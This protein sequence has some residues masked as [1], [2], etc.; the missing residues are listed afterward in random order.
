MILVLLFQ[1][2]LQCLKNACFR[3]FLKSEC[4]STWYCRW[5]FIAHLPNLK[6]ICKSPCK[7]LKSHLDLKF[8][9]ARNWVLLWELFVHSLWSRGQGCN[10]QKVETVDLQTI[11]FSIDYGLSHPLFNHLWKFST[12]FFL[13][14]VNTDSDTPLFNSILPS[15]YKSGSISKIYNKYGAPFIEI[16]PLPAC[17]FQAYFHCGSLRK[18][19]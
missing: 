14:Q 3:N 4:S 2:S 17:F 11:F 13:K 18:G 8:H 7:Y 12:D 15:F 19:S 16:V 9:S 1:I 6:I 10:K 5:L